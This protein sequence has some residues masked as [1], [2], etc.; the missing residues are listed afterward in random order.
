MVR[1]VF[2]LCLVLVCG[3]G[4]STDDV[5]AREPPLHLVVLQDVS[6]SIDGVVPRLRPEELVPALDY[7]RSHGGVV[8]FGSFGGS[9]RPLVR[10]SFPVP[11][12]E[13]RRVNVFV[14]QRALPAQVDDGAEAR[15]GFL[16][17]VADLLEERAS[18][19]NLAAALARAEVFFSEA[20]EGA[21]RALVL[22]SDLEDTSG[23]S[24]VRL[25]P[26]VRVLVVT[27]SADSLGLLAAHADRVALFESI[28]PALHRALEGA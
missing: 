25:A 20:P 27:D 8:A 26:G 28:L 7:A 16:A 24:S 6:G 12:A 11:V 14:R 19:T 3:C 5:A 2:F 10:A 18:Q 9:C 15:E 4:M 17:S 1:N 21:R 22:I 23:A 13:E